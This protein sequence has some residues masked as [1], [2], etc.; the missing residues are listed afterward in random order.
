VRSSALS[1]AVLQATSVTGGGAP[2]S[3]VTISTIDNISDLIEYKADGA[4]VNGFTITAATIVF[5]AIATGTSNLHLYGVNEYIVGYGPYGVDGLAVGGSIE[6]TGPVSQ[7]F[8]DPR[9]CWGCWTLPLLK[10]G[11]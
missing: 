11:S 10:V 2:F 4:T 8:T 9:C 3:N 7:F 1:P 6:V 5:E